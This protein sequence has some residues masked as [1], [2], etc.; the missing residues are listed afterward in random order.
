[1]TQQPTVPTTLEEL[2]QRLITLSHDATAAKLVQDFAQSLSKAQRQS[3]F[4]APNALLRSPI[5]YQDALT[6]G[7][8]SPQ[9]DAFDFLQGDVIGTEAAYSLGER[10]ENAKY[11][12]AN[13]SCDLVQGRRPDSQVLLIPVLH[14]QTRD[15]NFK[16]ILGEVLSF[17]S[18]Q[19]MYIPKLPNDPEDTV[20]N[21]IAFDNMALIRI[22]ALSLATRHASL[23]LVG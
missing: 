17:R 14:I 22:D 5:D 2:Q 12:I 16:Q 15:P 6:Q 1:V 18:N 4:N 13:S 21:Y 7:V 20:G 9:E 11:V 19:R 8:I 23:S 3:A 10:I